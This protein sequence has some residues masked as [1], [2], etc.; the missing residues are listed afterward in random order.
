M[1]RQFGQNSLQPHRT[2]LCF[3]SIEEGED[4]VNQDY[5]TDCTLE[6]PRFCNSEDYYTNQLKDLK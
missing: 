3:H 6:Y 4:T 1:R 2:K 5:P